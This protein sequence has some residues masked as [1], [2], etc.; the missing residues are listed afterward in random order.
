MKFATKIV[1]LQHREWSDYYLDYNGLKLILAELPEDAD[2]TKSVSLISKTFLVNEKETSIT[3]L[4]ELYRQVQKITLFVLHQQGQIA[5]QL[6]KYEQEQ[7]ECL[8]ALQ[9]QQHDGAVQNVQK[10]A[11][12][13]KLRESYNHVGADLLHLIQFVDL[14]V[15]GILRLLKKHDKRVTAPYKAY[16]FFL[17]GGKT[18][19]SAIR[20][21]NQSAT[22]MAS[23]RHPQALDALCVTLQ[24]AYTQ[25]RVV[26]QHQSAM[27]QDLEQPALRGRTTSAQAERL[28]K[29]GKTIIK[30]TRSPKGLP[31]RHRSIQG[32]QQLSVAHEEDDGEG[33]IPIKNHRAPSIAMP[34]TSMSSILDSR[35]DFVMAQIYAARRN[36][37]QNDSD[38]E[39]LNMLAT[40]ALGFLTE[41]PEINSVHRASTEPQSTTPA[42]GKDAIQAEYERA[43]ALAAYKRSS[44]ISGILNFVSSFIYMAN[45][46]IVVPTV[47]TYSEKLG[48][49]PALSSAIV[50]MTP[51]ATIFSTFLYSYWTSYSYR[52]P[53]LFAAS[54]NVAGNLVYAMGYPCNSMAFVLIGRLMCGL[55]SCRPINRRYIADAYSTAERTAASA[56]FVAVGSFGMALGPFLGSVLHRMAEHS[57][58]PYWQVE[59]A[60]GWFMSVVWLIYVIFHVIFFVDPPKEESE[61][62]KKNTTTGEK[63][64]LLQNGNGK[65]TQTISV[66][67]DD[68]D[69]DDSISNRI[70]I[71]KNSAVMVNFF[72]YFVEK[73]LMECVSSSTSILTYYY[74]QWPGSWAGYYLS[75]LCLLIL[76]VNL[77]VAY[78]SKTY[79]D[80][81]MMMVMQVVTIV[82]CFIILR[83]GDTYYLDQ[84][85]IGS[86][87]IVV[88]SNMVEGPNMSLLSKT[89]P[90]AWRKGF[91]NVGLL[92]TEAATL[93]RTAGDVFLALCGTGGIDTQLNYTFGSMAVL[94]SFTLWI[95][96]RYYDSL[97]PTEDKTL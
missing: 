12:L 79:E 68:N 32:L 14:N 38:N 22:M 49:D 20:A 28:P 65:E 64:P 33:F 37:Q 46:L 71:W 77:L 97:I 92:A 26:Q 54:L 16:D 34:S 55:G 69:D 15:K 52:T 85:L 23:L 84:Y 95:S 17:F 60:P 94:T 39:V 3:F 6:D 67:D 82:G 58:S 73:L 62:I 59:N 78:L 40:T 31:R 63:Q 43:V 11:Q 87:V 57:K 47:V 56:H 53:L 9:E 35:E 81:Q 74:F 96:Y 8:L 44:A 27:P 2:A 90:K 93:G 36:L 61:S 24:T 13:K 1:A 66:S 7:Q 21:Q 5:H 41:P 91:F 80:R 25:L 88:C 10:L 51:F 76:P 86:L 29:E 72:I 75:F 48:A 42:G 19:T 18:P 30:R 45:Y 4:A 89:I 83:Y 70:P 50:G